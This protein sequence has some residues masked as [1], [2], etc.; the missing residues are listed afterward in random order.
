MVVQVVWVMNEMM[1]TIRE[2]HDIVLHDRSPKGADLVLSQRPSRGRDSS[3][4]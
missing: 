2:V 3:V 4:R 1:R